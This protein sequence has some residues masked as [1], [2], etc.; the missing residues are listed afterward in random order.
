M[1]STTESMINNDWYADNHINP[2]KKR[3]MHL[4][5]V[6]TTTPA[7]PTKQQATQI[8]SFPV[9]VPPPQHPG[10]RQSIQQFPSY[11][12][13][14]NS[15]DKSRFPVDHHNY[16]FLGSGNLFLWKSAANCA[17]E[18]LDSISMGRPRVSHIRKKST[19]ISSSTLLRSWIRASV[20]SVLLAGT[21]TLS[22]STGSK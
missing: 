3:N 5:R 2:K 18:V 12:Y 17:I 10:Y 11:P 22:C 4:E 1:Y 14:T 20:K 6:P 15:S 13:H 9:R 7:S 8:P 16:M 19:L 21:S